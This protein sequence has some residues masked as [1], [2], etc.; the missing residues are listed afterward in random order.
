MVG[1][2]AETL[3]CVGGKGSNHSIDAFAALL[4]TAPARDGNRYTHQEFMAHYTWGWQRWSEACAKEI[5]VRREA[6]KSLAMLACKGN[7]QVVDVLIAQLEND[8]R[9]LRQIAVEALACI[10]DRN[11][12]RV[13]TALTAQLNHIDLKEAALQGLVE[14]VEKF[15]DRV[16]REIKELATRAIASRSNAL[17]ANKASGQ[18]SLT[19]TRRMRI[20]ARVAENGD[21]RVRSAVASLFKATDASLLVSNMRDIECHAKGSRRMMATIEARQCI[22]Q[23]AQGSRRLVAAVEILGAGP[24]PLVPEQTIIKVLTTQLRNFD[25]DW[26]PCEAQLRRVAHCDFQ[27]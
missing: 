18:D 1:R 16:V 26:R 12:Q 11:D 4:K 6:A 21:H 17:E 24:T 19:N 14:L 8:D 2:V 13:I 25:R 9:E 15:D 3:L 10:A 7:V 22:D 27:D 23:Y 5:P 20:L